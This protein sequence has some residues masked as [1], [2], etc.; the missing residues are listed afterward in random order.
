MD[1]EDL[2]SQPENASGC[3]HDAEN[4]EYGFERDMPGRDEPLAGTVSAH[5][6][7]AVVCTGRRRWLCG[8]LQKETGSLGRIATALKAHRASLAFAVKLTACDASSLVAERER[9]SQSAKSEE[10]L[11]TLS[12]LSVSA[13]DSSDVS[14]EEDVVDVLVFPDRVRVCGISTA[15]HVDQLVALLRKE[16]IE[17][18]VAVAS[19]ASRLPAMSVV[20]LSG[21][22]IF[23]C[24]HADMDKRCGYCG[25]RLVS[26]IRSKLT[27]DGKYPG[28]EEQVQ[29]YRSSHVGG[30]KWAGNVIC[31]PAG[32]WYGYVTPAVLDSVLDSALVHKTPLRTH[33]RGALGMDKEAQ[34]AAIANTE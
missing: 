6:R 32:F 3:L 5:G 24:S 12:G 14:V 16:Q 31:H 20:P 15:E 4:R 2:L 18:T 25:P 33:W 29:V 19:A 11:P 7:H 10:T 22:H 8:G 26:A 17:A 1:I 30:H 23:V 13:I 21:H 27:K 28:T 9:L 34:L